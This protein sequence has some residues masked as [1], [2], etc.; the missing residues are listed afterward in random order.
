MRKA[1]AAGTLAL[2]LV[3]AGCDRGADNVLVIGERFF[4]QQIEDIFR[5]RPQNMGRTIRYEGVFRAMHWAQT[6]TYHFYVVRYVMSCCGVQAIGFELLPD[7]VPPLQDETWVEVT[8]VLEEDGGFIVIRVISL[9]E[10]AE[11]GA[12]VVN[13]WN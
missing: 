12:E 11:R 2:A 13:F 1:L 9:I 5:N 3:L 4:V 10:M 8:G 6:D 7:N